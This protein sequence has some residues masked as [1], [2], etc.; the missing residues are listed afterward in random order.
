MN[1]ITNGHNA[2][3]HGNAGDANLPHDY[4]TFAIASEIYGIDILTVREIRGWTQE[5]PLPNAAPHMRGVINLRGEVVPILDLRLKLG[6]QAEAPS[7]TNVV[8]V[9]AAADN[10]CGLLVDSVSDILS[11]LP[12]DMQPVP[13]TALTGDHAYIAALATRDDRMVSLLDPVQLL[14]A[15]PALPALTSQ[16]A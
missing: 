15:R 10:V 16:A 6:A 1:E 2:S 3:D 5:N 12:K 14:G 9:V 8:I 7:H 4:L 13:A 11:L